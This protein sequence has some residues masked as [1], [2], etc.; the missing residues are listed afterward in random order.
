MINSIYKCFKLF[1]YQENDK[2]RTGYN[3]YCLTR[4]EKRLE[5]DVF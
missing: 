3:R 2:E 1:L 5:P 4:I